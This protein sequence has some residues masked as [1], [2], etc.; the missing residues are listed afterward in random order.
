MSPEIIVSVMFGSLIFAIIVLGAHLG[1]VLAIIAM[2]VGLMIWPGALNVIVIRVF[3]IMTNYVI[4]A[5]PMF[6]FMGT[7]LEKAGFAEDLYAGI[8]VIFGRMRGGLAVGTVVL[9]TA[10]AMCTGVVAAAIGTAGVMGLGPMLKRGYDKGLTCGCIAAGGTLGILIPPSVMLIIYAGLTATSVGKLFLAAFLPGF[11]LSALFIIYIFIISFLRPQMAPAASE[12]V[13]RQAAA[14]ARGR[15]L[16]GLRGIAPIG[17][18]IFSVLGTIIFGIATPTEASGTGAF[19][20]ILV[21]AAY[22]RASWENIRNGALTTVRLMGM[23]GGVM[24]GGMGFSTIFLTSG[25]GRLIQD[26][27]MGAE[28]APL[29][30]LAILMGILVLLGCFIGYFAIFLICLPIFLPIA[31]AM[32]WDP[33]WFA[34]VVC[35]NL[36][37]GWLTPPFGYALFWVRGITD[38]KVISFGTIIKGCVPFVLL[39]ATGLGLCIAFPQIILFLPTLVFR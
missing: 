11:L 26:L 25:G 20:A 24:I 31:N 27:L 38:P 14:T 16:R 36:Q 33:I 18:I 37:M 1:F 32:G 29:M 15:W 30:V 28:M 7:M 39:Q 9:S 6:I 23:M 35:V 12:E 2:A 10:I 17:V 34:L 22:R 4:I 13:L 5:V 8:D 21:A 19:A 3:S